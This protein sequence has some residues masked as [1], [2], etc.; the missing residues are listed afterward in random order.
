MTALTLAPSGVDHPV[1][2][3]PWARFFRSWTWRQGEHVT[4]VGPTG[5]GK[6]TLMRAL[7]RK[8]Y[9]AGG[10]VA[11]LAT[12]PADAALEAWARQDRLAVVDDWPPRPPSIFRTPP[13]PAPGVRWDHRVMVWPR[14]GKTED[15]RAIL[16]DVHRRALREM[17]WQGDW[18]I[19]AEELHYMSD[20]LNL[21]S[22]LIEIWTQGRSNRVSLIGGTQRPVNIP[23]Y[24]YSQAT[25]LFVFGDNDEVNL[26]RLQGIGGMSGKGL[27]AYVR[28]LPFHDV[29][30]IGT[31][32]RTLV[33][34]RVPVRKATTR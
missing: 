15:R 20:R 9:D 26:S 14:G 5:T 25:H 29:L 1:P 18:C 19:A 34:T 16:E 22:D 8:R 7:M 27:Q 32:Q 31:R 2:F 3:T 6:T 30:Y 12:K 10:A 33:R 13:E 4:I 28:A 11:V 24:A 23:L 17:F 21:D